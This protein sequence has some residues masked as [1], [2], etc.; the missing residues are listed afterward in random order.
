MLSLLIIGTSRTLGRAPRTKETLPDFCEW[1]RVIRHPRVFHGLTGCRRTPRVLGRHSKWAVCGQ[2]THQTLVPLFETDFC[3][4]FQPHTHE[5][6][7][8]CINYVTNTQI[9]PYTIM[10]SQNGSLKFPYFGSKIWDR[11]NCH[12]RPHTNTSSTKHLNKG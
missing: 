12:S 10:N 8:Y 3:G 6:I 2:P 7:I 4:H 11:S 5:N 1:C 9:S